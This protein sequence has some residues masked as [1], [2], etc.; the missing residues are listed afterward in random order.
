MATARDASR[1]VSLRLLALKVL[2]SYFDASAS[3]ESWDMANPP[4]F[5]SLGSLSHSEVQTGAQPPAKETP[6][7]ASVP[8]GS[9][10]CS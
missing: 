7:L 5:A 1:P 10:Q 2:V 6:Y 8:R 3:I 4:R 9:T